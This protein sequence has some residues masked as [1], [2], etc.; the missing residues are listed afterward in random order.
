M[1][2]LNP[3]QIEAFRMVMLRG[4]ITA[5]AQMLNVSQ[6]AVSR[7][8]RDLEVRSGL[9]LFERHGNHLLPTP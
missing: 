6:P 7:L 2:S 9:A 3:R 5:A 1:A 4:S 8:I